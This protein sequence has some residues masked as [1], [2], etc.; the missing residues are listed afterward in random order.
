MAHQREEPV[1][2]GDGSQIN[3]RLERA[4]EEIDLRH[5]VALI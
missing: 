3:I 1:M 5:T 4:E 2:L